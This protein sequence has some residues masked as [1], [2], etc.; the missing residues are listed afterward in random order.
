MIHL[1]KIE[2]SENR[3]RPERAASYDTKYERELHKRL[4]SW[5]ERRLV[6]RLLDRVGRCDRALDVPCGAGRLSGLIAEHASRLYE[7]DYSRQMLKL[8]RAN[9]GTYR[10]LVAAASAFQL[11]FP[12]R[13]FD[14]VV[15]IRLS[16]HIPEREARK[17]HLRELFRVSRRH[18][19]VTFFG[20]ESLKN[21][22]R[23]LYR[24]LGG[25][26]RSKHT[27]SR[28]E[29]EGLAREHGFEVLDSRVISAVFSGH[30]FALL[31]R[32]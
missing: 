21:R 28:G 24:R 25:R 26:K 12:D 2:Y 23:E 7:V 31:E 15:S 19:L 9:A 32:R 11:P 30:C 8:C 5:R 10:P 6:E 3:K 18:V 22:L 27:L 4:S 17:D 29:V 1:E 13:A 16:H 14:L 20:E